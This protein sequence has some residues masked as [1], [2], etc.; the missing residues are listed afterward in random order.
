M[1]PRAASHALAQKTTQQL[2]EDRAAQGLLQV[3][4]KCVWLRQV[5]AELLRSD[6][7][8]KLKAFARKIYHW[9]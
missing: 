6:M 8:V 3:C 2:H 4:T 9:R 7:H 5:V 1:T